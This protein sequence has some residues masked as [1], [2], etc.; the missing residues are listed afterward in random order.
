[1]KDKQSEQ[2]VDQLY[3]TRDEAKS[4]FKEHFK[5]IVEVYMQELILDTQIYRMSAMEALYEK[6]KDNEK[7]FLSHTDRMLYTAAAVEILTAPKDRVQH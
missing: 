6:L 2:I 7:K 5:D 4:L 1:M 3:K